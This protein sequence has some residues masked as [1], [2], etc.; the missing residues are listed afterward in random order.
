M[1][2]AAASVPEKG[3]Y[4]RSR[5]GDPGQRRVTALGPTVT[6]EFDPLGPRSGSP[7]ASFHPAV[8]GGSLVAVPVA[9]PAAVSD[10][11]EDSP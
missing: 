9:V 1:K 4:S 7:Q 3:Q 6:F 8:P 5:R 10:C 11:V 2:K